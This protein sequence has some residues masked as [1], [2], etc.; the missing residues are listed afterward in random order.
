MAVTGERLGRLSLRVDAAYCAVL[1]LGVIATAPLLKDLLAMPT[2][3]LV[4]VG[5]LTVAWA[6]GLCWLLARASLPVALR[7]VAAANIL[8]ASALAGFSSLAATAPL[9]I[10]LIALAID[11]ALFAGSQ[12]VAL[13]KSGRAQRS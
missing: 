2:S 11:I 4:A 5:G 13:V 3:G 8:A 12:L 6:G 9:T 10:A 1:G 7:I